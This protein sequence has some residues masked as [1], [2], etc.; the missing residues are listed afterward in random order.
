MQFR[1]RAAGSI[2]RSS[3][4]LLVAAII[5]TSTGWTQTSS[6]QSAPAPAPKPAFPQIKI[7]A[8]AY[9]SYQN[10]TT[11]DAKYSKFT[12]KRGYI[13]ISAKINAH[14]SARVTPDVVQDDTGDVKLRMKYAYG[15]LEAVEWGFI[16]NPNVEFGLVHAPWL[17]FEEHVNN[18]R[19]QDA[20]FVDRNALAT[21]A[22]FGVTFAGLLGGELP[23]SYRKAV[24][25]DYPGRFGS[26]A[27]GVYNGGGYAAKE[28]NRNKA[29]EARL[30][31]RPLPETIPGLQ[32]S[33]MGVSGKGNT[34][35][36]PD[37]TLNGVMGSYE[38]ERFVITGQW[39]KGSGNL[40]GDQVD[41]S[42]RALD[43]EGW[44]FFAEGKFTKEWRAIFRYDHFDPNTDATSDVSKRTIVGVAY[45]LAK[46]NL[47]LLDYDRVDY[48]KPGKDSDDRVQATLQVSF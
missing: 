32:L 16:T 6:E 43:R 27:V 1:T 25:N 7:G 22:D 18:Y 12:I 23:D 24:S 14:L 33:Y 29:L 19:L 48:E 11:S 13:N 2:A 46:S 42:A 5:S 10:G 38:H 39:V 28:N 37:W 17:D 9:L 26:F 45:C 30:T 34:A 47:I 36:E 20:M 15:K 31:I 8:L 44:S 4:A 3:V 40:K 21:S 41:L 35:S